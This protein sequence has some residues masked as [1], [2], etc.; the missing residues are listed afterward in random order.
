[1]G[2]ALK[3]TDDILFVGKEK[4][5]QFIEEMLRSVKSSFSTHRVHLGMDEAVTLGLG[6]YLMQNGYKKLSS[7]MKED[8][9]LEFL[10][11]K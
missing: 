11:C 2:T 8:S 4:V 10:I 9:S 5:Y 7:L 3:D 1:M 6:N